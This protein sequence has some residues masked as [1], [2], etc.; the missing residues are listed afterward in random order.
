MHRRSEETQSYITEKYARVEQRHDESGWRNSPRTVK[1]ASWL[2]RRFSR[3]FHEEKYKCFQRFWELSLITRLYFFRIFKSWEHVEMKHVTRLAGKL[4]RR[5][6]VHVYIYKCDL[7]RKAQEAPSR[8]ADKREIM[9]DYLT[10][11][12]RLTDWRLT[13]VRSEDTSNGRDA[14]SGRASRKHP[15]EK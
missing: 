5:T 11:R 2:S 13:D 6:C 10:Y 9:L 8:V 15:N 12:K 4:Y 1:L 14:E 3:H 7:F